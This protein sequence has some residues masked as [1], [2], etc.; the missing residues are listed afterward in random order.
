MSAYCTN[1]PLKLHNPQKTLGYAVHRYEVFVIILMGILVAALLT[2]ASYYF[3]S[4]YVS[5][6]S[7]PQY[8]MQAENW[9]GYVTATDLLNPQ[10]NATSING[11]WTIPYVTDVGFD[12]FSAVWVGIGGQYGKDLIQLG[13][14]QDFVGGQAVYSAWYETLP[15]EATTIDSIHVSP[16]DRIEASVVLMDAGLNVWAVSLN[17]LT[18]GQSFSL[19][20]SY[21]SNRTSVEWIVERPDV[22]NQLSSLADFGKVTFTGCH[23]DFGS[24]GSISAFANAKVVMISQSSGQQ[25]TQLTD[26]S[27]L[28]G[29]GLGFT[30]NYLAS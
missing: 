3:L 30:V 9:A 10:S 18:S 5:Y 24:A 11:S 2:V 22:N 13:T 12:A 26:V 28:S 25:S 21:A 19:N 4:T 17:D 29:D 15:N 27:D 23:A 1:I 16:G 6:S 7:A 14:E 20:I 8:V